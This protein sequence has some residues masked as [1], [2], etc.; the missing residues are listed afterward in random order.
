MMLFPVGRYLVPMMP[1]WYLCVGL[2]LAAVVGWPKRRMT[3]ATAATR[4]RRG[5]V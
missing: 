2:V 4:L 3:A 5:A 1:V